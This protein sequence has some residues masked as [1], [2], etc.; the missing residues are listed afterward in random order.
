MKKTVLAFAFV[1]G[2]FVVANAQAP[3]GFQFGGGLR[4]SVPVG[5]FADTHSFGLGAEVQGEFGLSTKFSGIVTS[6]Y[7]SFFGKDVSTGGIT[8]KY[9]ANGYIPLLAGA[10]YYASSNFF[11]GAQAGLGIYTY[12]G[13]SRSGFNWQPQLGYNADNFQVALGY[14]GLS[15]N[16]NTTSHIGLTGIYKFN[17]GGSARK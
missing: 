17:T 3:E 1:L 6:G 7:T 4:A 14:N 2:T 10:R 12:D 16:G 13:D 15:K 11:I 5:D 8:L 9:K